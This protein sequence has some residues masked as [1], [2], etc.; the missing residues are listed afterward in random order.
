MAPAAIR[1]KRR[2]VGDEKDR[3]SGRLAVYLG[4]GVVG[5]YSGV[6]R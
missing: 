1:K 3:P 4:A 6:K 2:A 5:K